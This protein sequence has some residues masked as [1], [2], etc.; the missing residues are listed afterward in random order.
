MC[1]LPSRQ[2]RKH[3]HDMDSVL[4]NP[5][6]PISAD[7]ARVP[8]QKRNGKGMINVA[9]QLHSRGQNLWLGWH[10]PVMKP[11]AATGTAVCR[12]ES[13]QMIWGEKEIGRLKTT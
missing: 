6:R 5:S 3:R 9:R 1:W 13:P 11:T 10:D 4:S 2:C 7:D 12:D 8:V